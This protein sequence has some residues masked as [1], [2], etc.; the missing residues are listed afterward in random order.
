MG[1]ITESL[2]CESLPDQIVEV[3][4]DEAIAYMERAL[5]VVQRDVDA[6][7]PQLGKLRL[8][9]V[10]ADGEYPDPEK[11]E[12]LFVMVYV[13]LQ[14]GSYYTGGSD[15]YA[16]GID[17]KGEVLERLEEAV[18]SVAECVQEFMVSVELREWPTC[19][20]HNRMLGPGS[21]KWRCEADGG[22]VVAT[23]GSLAEV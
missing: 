21:M 15:V 16:G 5:G 20:L 12:D 7:C 2:W 19:P 18:Y 23:I 17:M 3:I 10:T 8:K 6:T 13:A 11:I 9:W 4:G 1:E 14:G 22:H